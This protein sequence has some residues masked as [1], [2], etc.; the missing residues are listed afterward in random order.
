MNRICEFYQL[1]E[2]MYWWF[3]IKNDLDR[4][5]WIF[6]FIYYIE[7]VGLYLNI[8]VFDKLSLWVNRLMMYKNVYEK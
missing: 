3:Y 8:Y 2:I 1:L 6:Y 5:S 4:I 7:C